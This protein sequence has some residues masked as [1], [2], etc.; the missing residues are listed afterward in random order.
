MGNPVTELLV[1]RTTWDH[2]MLLAT[3][4]KQKP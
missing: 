1:S 4:H 2:R 3:R